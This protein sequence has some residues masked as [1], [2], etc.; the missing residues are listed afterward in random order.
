[1]TSSV[2][3]ILLVFATSIACANSGTQVSYTIGATRD[4]PLPTSEVSVTILKEKAIDEPPDIGGPGTTA[5]GKPVIESLGN[6][7]ILSGKRGE[8]KCRVGGLANNTV[9]FSKKINP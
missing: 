8:L 3:M 6:V 2:E 1:M 9:G 4:A 7:T 5:S